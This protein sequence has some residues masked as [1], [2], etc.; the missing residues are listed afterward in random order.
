MELAPHRIEGLSIGQAFADAVCSVLR[1]VVID[2]VTHV[3]E[4]ESPKGDVVLD[5][6]TH[7][8]ATHKLIVS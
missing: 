8:T 5:D 6:I 3:V 4:A 7:F 1:V 2:P